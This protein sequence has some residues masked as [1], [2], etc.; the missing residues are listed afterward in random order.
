MNNVPSTSPMELRGVSQA[1]GNFLKSCEGT[2]LLLQKV[3]EKTD[4]SLL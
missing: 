4:E 2:T 1:T 3:Q